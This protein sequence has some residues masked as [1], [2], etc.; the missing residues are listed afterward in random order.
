M[1]KKTLA[2]RFC[3]EVV[4]EAVHIPAAGIFSGWICTVPEKLPAKN[5]IV[6]VKATMPLEF[7]TATVRVPFTELVRVHRTT[8][9]SSHV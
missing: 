9:T 1:L 4:M 5:W 6:S 3:G 8:I 2:I 7:F